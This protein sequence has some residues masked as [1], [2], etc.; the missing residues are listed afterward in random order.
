[1]IQRSLSSRVALFLIFA[2]LLPPV[3]AFGAPGDEAELEAE[4]RGGEVKHFETALDDSTEMVEAR[5]GEAA[6]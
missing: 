4:L 1:M 3:P 2:L 5:G 6:G